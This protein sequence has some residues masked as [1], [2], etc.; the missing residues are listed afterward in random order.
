MSILAL[1]T[2]LK[3]MLR[4]GASLP[5]QRP[6]LP[7]GSDRD[8]A[9]AQYLI[10]PERLDGFRCNSDHGQSLPFCPEDFGRVSFFTIRGHMVLHQAQQITAAKPV[11]RQIAGESDIGVQ[12]ERHLA[13]TSMGINVMNFVVPDK[14]SVIQI[15]LTRRSTPTG[16]CRIPT[17][18]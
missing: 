7:G 11:F 12:W 5:E 9:D 8:G 1:E 14:R 2:Y 17:I 16:P 18:S 4:Y 13:K 3:S 6:P 15:V 10:I